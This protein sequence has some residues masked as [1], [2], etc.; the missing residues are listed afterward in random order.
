MVASHMVGGCSVFGS[1]AGL[2][3]EE[4]GYDGEPRSSAVERR[5]RGWG[6]S[7]HSASPLLCHQPLQREPLGLVLASREVGEGPGG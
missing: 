6:A 4:W 3:E 1:A 2:L 5:D 7:G